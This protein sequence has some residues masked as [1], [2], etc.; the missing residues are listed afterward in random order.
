MSKVL[1]TD[2]TGMLEVIDYEYERPVIEDFTEI[3]KHDDHKA[4]NSSCKCKTDC[5]AYYNES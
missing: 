3:V 1:S 4:L 2:L 5:G